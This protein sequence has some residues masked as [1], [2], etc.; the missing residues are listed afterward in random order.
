[1]IFPQRCVVICCNDKRI[2]WCDQ[3]TKTTF[4][5]KPSGPGFGDNAEQKVKE[6]ENLFRSYEVVESTD[7]GL[8][9]DRILA[10]FGG[11]KE[12]FWKRM[13]QEDNGGVDW[14]WFGDYAA[15]TFPGS[16]ERENVGAKLPKCLLFFVDSN[17]PHDADD[18]GNDSKLCILY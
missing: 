3:R 15:L 1:M 2:W 5:G 12:S 14:Q 10:E 6:L 4:Q 13:R 11:E 7:S 8:R 9:M 16:D 17:N 18:D